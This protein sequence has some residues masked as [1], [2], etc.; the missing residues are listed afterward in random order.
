MTRLRLGIFAGFALI[1][2]TSFYFIS[3]GGGGGGDVNTPLSSGTGAEGV[4]IFWQH[5][6][7]GLGGG[8]SVQETSDKGFILAGS[9][10][11]GSSNG[12]DIYVL[13]TDAQG[14]VQWQ[15]TFGGSGSDLGNAVLQAADG[16]YIV[17]GCIDCSAFTN[18]FYLLKLDGSGNK[19]AEKSIAGASLDGAYAVRETKSGGI[20]DGYVI[21]GSDVYQ[22]VALIKTDLTGSILWQRSFA[23]TGQDAGWDAGLA[24]DQTTDGGYII[25]GSFA[26]TQVWL[27]KTDA[28]GTKL[29]DK[30]LG[31]GEGL[32]VKQTEDNGY[33]IAGRTTLPRMFGGPPGDAVVI[34]T[35]ED[36][37][38]LWKKTFGGAE[39]DEARS[40]AL[41]LDGGYIIAGKTLSYGT[42]PVDYNQ[43][44]QWEDVF[45]IKLDANGDTV[46]QKVKGHRPNSSDG[47]ASVYAVSDGGYV[48]TG[49]SNAY[50][51]GTVL[52]MKTDKNGDTVNL[53]DE[54]L[55]VTVP[56]SL[57]TINFNNAI[58]VAAAGVAAVKDP[59]DVGAQTIDLLIAAL[60]NDPVSDFCS[61]G[62]YTMSPVP[63]P[64]LSTGGTYT[65]V[66][67]DCANGTAGESQVLNGSAAITLE[68]VSGDPLTGNYSLQVTINSLNITAVA[69]ASLSS[70]VTGG[71][72][73]TRTAASGSF[74]E[75]A[76]S[77]DTPATK[78]TV[79]EVD[80]T[81]TRMR[82]IG[83]FVLNDSVGATGAYSYGSPSDTATVDFGLGPLTV[84]VVT[85]VQGP[86]PGTDPTSGSFTMTAADN[87]RISVVLT[88]GVAVI[89]VDTDGDGTPDGTIAA[90]WEFLN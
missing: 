53:G 68:S 17:A 49:N 71:M 3:C 45:L 63:V 46:W 50:P 55:T 86:G 35:D 39:D 27:I 77:I 11:S 69:S 85:S 20:P 24:L 18:N 73:I 67:A 58:E 34:R 10:N 57:G 40:V 1:I 48:V 19:V 23:S 8:S 2:V 61:S 47:G 7:S 22:D 28:N 88:N 37:N 51:D 42:G 76:Q 62:S 36:G 52:L 84:S 65:L 44:W 89:A 32:S 21:S 80:G 72:Q 81:T 79:V 90:T 33:I 5:Y 54:D 78:L 38:L 13:K 64:S 74:T 56:E 41:T 43:Y 12:S 6:G 29:W 30:L 9:Q 15:K 60:K 26:G 75:L 82:T 4:T 16:G 66:L 14:S 59:H 83:P 31:P 87:S 25:S 70:T